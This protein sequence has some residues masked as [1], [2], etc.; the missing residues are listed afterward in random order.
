MSYIDDAGKEMLDDNDLDLLYSLGY[1]V[2][3]M[4][5]DEIAEVLQTH[6]QYQS[7]RDRFYEDPAIL[8]YE[9]NAKNVIL[10]GLE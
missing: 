8:E 5:D 7:T 2:D 6:E 9:E 10:K 1:D 3:N 4:S